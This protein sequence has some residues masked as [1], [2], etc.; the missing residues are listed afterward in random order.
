MKTSP[1]AKVIL[2]EAEKLNITHKKIGTSGSAFMLSRKD[3]HTFIYQSLTEMIGDPAYVIAS[4]KYLTS[5]TLKKHGFPV[6]TFKLIRDYKEALAFLKKHKKIVIKPLSANR[7]KGITIGV[8]TREELREAVNFAFANTKKKIQS[9]YSKCIIA[10]KAVPGDDHRVLVIDYKHVFAIKKIPAYVVGDGKKNIRQLIWH[11][12]RQKKE[13]KKRII[14]DEGLEHVLTRQDLTL[15]SV[16]DEDQRVYVR[17]TAN[18]ATGGESRDITDK[19]N[20]KI[21]E[22]AIAAARALKMPVAGF[23][24]MCRDY[25]DDKGY[26][27]EVNP[28]PGF[29][30][31]RYPHFGRPRN[32]AKVMLQT[33]IKKGLL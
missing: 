5:F 16:P 29:M 23:D 31:H 25:T 19:L 22:M 24:F 3:K 8:K 4:N 27:I 17:R 26:F 13:H 30:I 9:T 12:N 11:K 14:I 33:L 20:P 1:Y 6:P 18:L 21:K 2:K 7:G 15:Q 10:E 32:P 28:I